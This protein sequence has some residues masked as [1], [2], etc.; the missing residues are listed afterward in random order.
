MGKY[1]IF[2]VNHLS[3][4]PIL[5]LEDV[6]IS[7]FLSLSLSIQQ[8]HTLYISDAEVIALGPIRRDRIPTEAASILRMDLF[9]YVR[10]MHLS[11]H[12][13]AIL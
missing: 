10:C 7:F 4:G 1:P 9:G 3:H 6:N 11:V 12:T 2:V 13:Y 5:A 8:L